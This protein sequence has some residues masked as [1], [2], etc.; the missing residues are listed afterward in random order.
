[1]FSSP[2]APRVSR[3]RDVLKA[4]I[5]EVAS[6]LGR[7]AP[8][9]ARQHTET[10]RLAR[11]SDTPRQRRRLPILARGNRTD[12][13]SSSAFGP[14]WRLLVGYAGSSRHGPAVTAV[15]GTE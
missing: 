6:V 4:T 3:G 1:M 15:P 10:P 2:R 7:R 11:T 5:D 12:R 9:S 8:R 13:P 14:S